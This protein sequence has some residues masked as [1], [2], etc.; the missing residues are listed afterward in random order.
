MINDIRH[1]RQSFFGVRFHHLMIEIICIYMLKQRNL[2]KEERRCR[3]SVREVCK[4]HE[5][6]LVLFMREE[7][8]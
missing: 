2:L 4:I 8:E 3:S 6:N 7:N 5:I 1:L